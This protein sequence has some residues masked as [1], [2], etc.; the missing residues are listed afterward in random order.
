MDALL[1]GAHFHIFEASPHPDPKKGNRESHLGAIKRARDRGYPSVMIVE[2][3][4]RV[5]RDFATLPPF[6]DEWQLVYLGGL[7][8]RVYEAPD[9]P[10]I[11]Y[12]GD[13]YCNH[14]YVVGAMSMAGGSGRTS[15]G[16][17]PGSDS[18]LRPQEIP[19]E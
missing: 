5:V 3:D 1:A 16:R 13:V 10:S 2:D 17:A 14:A 12:Q 11:W 9:P 19:H 8:T 15:S 4:I 6:P 7:C 18:C